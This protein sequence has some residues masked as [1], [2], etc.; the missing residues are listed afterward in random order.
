MNTGNRADDSDKL[1]RRTC[2]KRTL[3]ECRRLLLTAGAAVVLHYAACAAVDAAESSSGAVT[4]SAGDLT[5]A[6]VDNEAH[7]EDHRAGYNGIARLT[8]AAQSESVFVPAYAGFNLEHIFG[9]DRMPDLF[10]PRH[11]P[12]T[13]RRLSSTTIELRQ[14]PTP[15]SA[16]ESTTRFQVVPPH[17]IDVEFR[18]VARDLTYFQHGYLGLFW[19]SYIHAPEDIRMHFRGRGPGDSQ[20]RWISAHTAEHG[21]ASTHRGLADPGDV[22]FAPDFNATLANHF[23]EYRFD[24]PFFCG[25]FRNMILL[26]MFD[27][28]PEIRFSQSPNGGG[29]TNPAWDFQFLARDVQP[30]RAYGYRARVAYKPFVSF[31][32]AAEEFRRWRE[33]ASPS[34]KR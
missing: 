22:F 31:D 32:A 27:R 24:A 4:I 28:A 25:R 10:E 26:Y 34:T 19:A 11:H 30:G 9:G 18:C 21:V 1:G 33:P 8:H 5:A 2:V 7:G 15:R 6:F 17:Y 14:S 3:D 12:M 20:S 13:L 29:S 16:V 23:S